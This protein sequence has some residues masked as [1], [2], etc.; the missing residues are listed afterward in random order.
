MAIEKQT[1]NTVEV[2]FN[3][4]YEVRNVLS[5]DFFR[6][7]VDMHLRVAA[8]ARVST[9][10]EEQQTSYYSQLTHYETMIKQNK[11]WEFVGV[12]ADEGISG[13]QTKKRDNF[14]RMI[15]DAL[16]GKIDMI[17]AKSI[18]RFARNTVDTLN[19]VR[20]L[21]SHNVD[22]FFEKENIH[23]L[24]ITNELF[25][26]LYSA[27]AQGESES[28]SENMKSGLQ[29]KMKRGEYV[30]NPNCYGYNWI[31][32][33]QELVVNED[34]AKV[35]VRIFEEYAKGYGTTIIARRLNEDGIPSPRG[36]R[37]KPE[38]IRRILFNEKYLGDL[39]SGKSFVESVITHKRKINT[40][41]S[42]QWYT[43]DRH[44]AIITKELWDK[45]HEMYK[46][47]SDKSK[48]HRDKYSRRYP[49]SSIIYCGDCGERFV[50]RS[51]R[52]NKNKPNGERVIFW[53]CR[54]VFRDEIE[55]TNR[56]TYKDEE[57][58]AMFV[59]LYNQL[60][61]DKDK[62]VSSFMSKVD[63]ILNDNNIIKEKSK[64]EKERENVIAK[65]S[66]LLDLSMDDKISKNLLDLKMSELN[67]QL[68]NIDN[69]LNEIN[70]S[71]KIRDNKTEQLHKI[72]EV[73]E[74]KRQLTEF[75][76]EV[77]EAIVDRIIVGETKEDGTFDY[78]TIKFIL[79]TGET[80]VNGTGIDILNF[81]LQEENDKYST[82][83]YSIQ[84]INENKESGLT[85]Y[86]QNKRLC[87]SIR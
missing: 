72:L 12:Y 61:N 23:T 71:E 49:F 87:I 16:D 11:N 85:A 20:L 60:Y 86:M 35:V 6:T 46:M 81:A 84:K 69:R 45:A 36:K 8:Y 48:K 13:T 47:R 43:T 64:L 44:E 77:F 50:R 62:Y 63:S 74:N 59:F 19:I 57:L 24:S 79:K 41:Q 5:K 14:N 2:K 42:K 58:K 7:Y 75:D 4:T 54:S 18:S 17:I 3:E 34:E 52:K 22:V 29:M 32:D 65:Q 25:L 51:Y 28:I 73:I 37:W 76:D 40:G 83:H 78:H 27:F 82:Y 66:K 9:D 68:L 38:T 1:L 15:Q 21:R 55:C 33:T 10:S 31:V 30:G 80:L 70:D 39:C 67:N 53:G 26:T 56:L